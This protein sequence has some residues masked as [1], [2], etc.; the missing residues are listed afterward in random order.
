MSVIIVSAKVAKVTWNVLLRI[1]LTLLEYRRANVRAFTREHLQNS[2]VIRYLVIPQLYR[3]VAAFKSNI[4][5][6]NCHS[7]YG[8]AKKGEKKSVIK[9]RFQCDYETG[10]LCCASE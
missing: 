2:S 6:D 10:R 5:S 7:Y 4:E 1:T 3:I 8:G 9:S